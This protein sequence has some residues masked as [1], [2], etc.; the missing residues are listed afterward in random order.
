MVSERTFDSATNR[1]KPFMVWSARICGQLSGEILDRK[2]IVFEYG[3]PVDS[4]D[5]DTQRLPR[6]SES[7]GVPP[8]PAPALA[9]SECAPTRQVIANI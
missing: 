2:A 3:F 5:P 6:R 9:V 4:V 1:R 8:H 7:V